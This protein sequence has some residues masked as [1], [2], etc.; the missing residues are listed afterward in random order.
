MKATFDDFIDQH[1]PYKNFA[2][3]EIM[4]EIFEKV[5]SSEESIAK[6]LMVSDIF[7]D[8]PALAVCAPQIDGYDQQANFDLSNDHTKQAL[9]AMVQTILMPFGYCKVGEEKVTET[10][11]VKI[12][13]AAVYKKTGEVKSKIIYRREEVE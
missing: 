5:L 10:F 11:S 3:N 12:H 7:P 4:R 6:M 8:F 9:G 1:N 13:N 2:G